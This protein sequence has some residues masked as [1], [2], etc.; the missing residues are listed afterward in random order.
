M[1]YSDQSL[2]SSAPPL[3]L[4][5]RKNG[6]EDVR[7]S[8]KTM[9]LGCKWKSVDGYWTV[10][11]AERILWQTNREKEVGLKGGGGGDNS[12]NKGSGV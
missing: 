1:A 9:G 10:V 8:E 5:Q 2:S 7:R 6:C 4:R 11:A 12:N 3:L